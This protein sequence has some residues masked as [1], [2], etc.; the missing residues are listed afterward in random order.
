MQDFAVAPP[1]ADSPAAARRPWRWF[2]PSPNIPTAPAW[3]AVRREMGGCWACCIVALPTSSEV[4]PHPTVSAI[5]DECEITGGG[6]RP[7]RRGAAPV[8][9]TLPAVAD[10]RRASMRR[11]LFDPGS[12]EAVA[13]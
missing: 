2:I 7:H 11:R 4:A 9:A 6:D 3:R 13:V 10:A 12:P 1:E 8:A 5:L